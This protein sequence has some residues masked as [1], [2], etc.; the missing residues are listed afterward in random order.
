MKVLLINNSKI[1]Y[2]KNEISENSEIFTVQVSD[3]LPEELDEHPD[4]P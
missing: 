2:L 3:R 1:R 4:V